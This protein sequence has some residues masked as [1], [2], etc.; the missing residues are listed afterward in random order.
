MSEF[1]SFQL[2]NPF[3]YLSSA[4]LLFNAYAFVDAVFRREDAYRAADKKTKPFWLVILGL[5]LGFD[6]LFGASIFRFLPLIGLVAAIVYMV[7]V[8]P[9]IQAVT[10]GR[11][12]TDPISRAL[13][14]LGRRGGGRPRW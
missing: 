6:L 2:L 14:A 12:G 3:W 1:L 4:I 10:A 5:A 7:D 11:G 9:A 8:R 13:R